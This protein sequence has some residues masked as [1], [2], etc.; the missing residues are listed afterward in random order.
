M[1]TP[2]F[3]CV[4]SDARFNG[5]LHLVF[6]VWASNKPFDADKTLISL[7]APMAIHTTTRYAQARIILA[8]LFLHGENTRP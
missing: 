6:A 8:Q 7:T 5:P 1:S 4:Y 2:K 3:I